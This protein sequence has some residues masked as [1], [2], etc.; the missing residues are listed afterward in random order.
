MQINERIRQWL[1][2]DRDYPKG[3]E[4]LMEV[5]KK[6]KVMGK[7]SKGES[8]TRREKLEYELS[9]YLKTHPDKAVL[10]PGSTVPAKP[11]KAEKKH[12]TE[13]RFSLIRKEEKIEDF[14]TGMQ[15]IIRENSSLYIHRGKLHKQLIRLSQDNSEATIA[16]R[17]ALVKKIA[18]ASER[19][20]QLYAVWSEFKK[21]GKDGSATLYQQSGTTGSAGLLTVEDLKHQKKNLQASLAKDRNMLE[22]Q[23]KTKPKDGNPTPMPEGPK[24]IRLEKRIKAKEKQIQDL[25]L[26]IA[27][28]E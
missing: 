11:D 9:H 1:S 20:E 17:E 14:P 7:L 8:K 12:K 10:K 26:L 5:S 15:R 13:V 23:S 16:D 22:Y 4:L 2:S 21:T 18:E 3:L 19:L 25:D 28:H 27:K 6:S 24:R